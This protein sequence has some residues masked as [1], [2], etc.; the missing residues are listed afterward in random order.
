M[1]M[2]APIKNFHDAKMPPSRLQ[3][4]LTAVGEILMFT[5]MLFLMFYAMPLAVLWLDTL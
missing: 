5:G 2:A 1:T 4:F 3:A